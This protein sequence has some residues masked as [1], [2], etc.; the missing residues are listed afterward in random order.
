MC[1]TVYKIKYSDLFNE[2]FLVLEISD[3]CK[4]IDEIKERYV[5]IKIVKKNKGLT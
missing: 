2:P 1:N 5:G 3:Y 4:H